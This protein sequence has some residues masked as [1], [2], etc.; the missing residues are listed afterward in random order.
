M[1]IQKYSSY[2]PFSTLGVQCRWFLSEYGALLAS[3]NNLLIL[4]SLLLRAA[5]KTL[6]DIS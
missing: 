2:G 4:L 5:L 6:S 3:V 1:I